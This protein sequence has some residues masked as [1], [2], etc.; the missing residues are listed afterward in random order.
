MPELCPSRPLFSEDTK[1]AEGM[2]TLPPP[3]LSWKSHWQPW[4]GDGVQ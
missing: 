4:A 1:A 2:L 3:Q